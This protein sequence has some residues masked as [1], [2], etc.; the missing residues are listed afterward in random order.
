MRRITCSASS[1][2]ATASLGA[3]L[4]PPH[5]WMAS[6]N[7]PVPRPNSM[8]PFVR[9]SRVATDFAKIAG[10]LIGR[11]LT[12]GKYLIFLVDAAKTLIRVQVSRKLPLYG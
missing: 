1:Y 10:A 11:S 8:R 4:V 3:L 9:I 6:Q 5:D 2:A 7:A 12:S